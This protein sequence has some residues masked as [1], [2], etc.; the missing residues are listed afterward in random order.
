MYGVLDTPPEPALDDLT[1]LTATICETPIAT[2]TLVDDRRQWFKS[3]VGLET[4]ETPREYSFC[5]HLLG[6]MDLFVVPDTMKDP[7]FAQNPLVTGAPH[8]RFYAGAP[9]VTPD[10]AVLGALC[11][12]DRVP[13]TLKPGQEQKLRVLVRQVMGQLELHRREREVIRLSRLYAA[14]S[15]VNQA[16]LRMPTRSEL[17]EQVCRVLVQHGGFDLA[18]IGWHMVDA[19]RIIPV[20]QYGD[21]SSYLHSVEIHTDDRPTGRGPTGTACREGRPFV[22][23]DMLTDPATLPWRE[24]VERRHWRAGAAFPIRIGGEV[25]AALTVYAKET[26]YFRDEEI[27]LL[28]EAAGNLSFALDNLARD[29]ARRHAETIAQNET[30]FSETMMESMPG[31]LYFYDDQGRFLRWSRSLETTTGHS[32]EEIARMHPIDFFANADR[33]LIAERIVEVFT[34]GE[35]SVEA[36]FLTKDGRSIPYFFT[37]CRVI[38]E[39]KPC[40]VGIGID[41]SKRKEAETRLA[42]SERKYRELVEHANSIILRWNSAGQVTLLNEYG[43]RFFGYSAEEILGRNVVGTI[44]PETESTGRDLQ[45]LMEGIRADPRMF[46]QNVNENVRRNGERVWISWTNR[47]QLDDHGRVLEIL[48]IG[49]DITEQR[50]A[51]QAIRELNASLEQRVTERTVELQTALIRAEAADRLKSAFLATMSHELRTPLNSIIGFTGTVLQGL[52][53]PLNA[54]QT[55]QLGMVRSSSRH[56]LELIN[57]VL[58]LSKIEAGQLRVRSESFDLRASLERT[59]ASVKPLADKKGLA[60]NGHIGPEIGSIVS[61]RRRVEQILLNLLNNAIKFTDRG[62]VTMT[63]GLTNESTPLPGAPAR[64]TVYLKVADTG[65]GIQPANI[66]TLFRPFRQLDTGISRQHEGTGLGLAICQ[67][68]VTLL[69]GRI[70]VASEWEKGSEFTVTLPLENPAEP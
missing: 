57:D 11:V 68:L 41:I 4:Q 64:P 6:Q 10:G 51:E 22:C 66:P 70:S 25:C 42:E 36:S 26:D 62:S 33:P 46:E 38:F 61:D 63:A 7:C 55:K 5:A 24:Q 14:L 50:H 1:R 48:S 23:N 12:M 29:E 32:A 69:G 44:V 31:V 43:Q 15:Q 21:E 16:I 19:H 34:K 58:D 2:I 49:T 27:R 13:R 59:I 67:R 20:A 52:A 30:R 17:F 35:S 60:L 47:I 65:I 37:G 9:L 45:Q 3:R 56:L 39:G 40:L 53:G 8:I 28:E 54:E 18:W